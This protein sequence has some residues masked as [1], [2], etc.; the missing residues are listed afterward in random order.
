MERGKNTDSNAILVRHMSKEMG[1]EAVCH[2]IVRDDSEALERALDT[3]LA[4]AD[5]V[6]IN[7]GSSK[8]EEDYN[9]RLLKV[10][11]DIICHGVAAAPGEPICIAMINQKPVVNLPGP[12]L[13]TYYGL[14]W[15]IGV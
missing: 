11:G 5:I 2:P 9:A 13:A 4:E 6:I 7:G 8:G 15:C 12:S 14:D 3:G 1:A 10:R